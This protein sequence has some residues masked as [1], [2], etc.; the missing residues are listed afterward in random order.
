MEK[1][2]WMV[3]QSSAENGHECGETEVFVK[4]GLGQITHVERLNAP[5]FAKN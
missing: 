4:N 3:I 5:N 2:V 1:G